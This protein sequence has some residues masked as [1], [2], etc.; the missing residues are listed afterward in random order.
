MGIKS[1]KNKK[2]IAEILEKNG[3][4]SVSELAPVLK[5][6][7]FTIRRYLEELEKDNIL[8]R[9]YGGAVKKYNDLSPE[10]F[11]REKA[12]RHLQEK[13]I[14][15]ELAISL[16]KEGET[17]FLDTGTTT[18]EI[19][20]LLARSEKN[21]VVA[22]N[23]LP[24]V[25]VISQVPCI[26]VFVL[27]GFL[28]HELMDFAGPFSTK[29]IGILNFDQVFLGVDGISAESGLTT[30]DI[31]TAKVEEA[32]MDRTRT[33]NIVADSSKIG[34]VSLI[35]YGSIKE[36][37]V[38]RILITDFHAN[39]EELERIKKVGIEVKIAR[40]TGEGKR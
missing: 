37:K 13:K 9:T 35:P 22:T 12:K 5:V 39:K 10:F 8:T 25:S 36:R 11:F 15:A 30:T 38:Q 16:I 14:I 32:V 34:K 21:L 40:Q 31:T 23:S 33:I 20:H 3:T 17:I 24:V 28:R 7:E 1:I 26:K 19:A 2:R 4:V 29:E 18:L 27:G 6:S